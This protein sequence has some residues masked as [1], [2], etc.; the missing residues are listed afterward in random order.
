MTI[1]FNEIPAR[2]ERP[3]EYVEIAALYSALGILPFP[4]RALIVA[5]KLAAAGTAVVGTAYTI[6]RKQDATALFGA[7]SQAET[8]AW[9]YLAANSTVPLDVMAVADAGGSTAATGNFTI[10]AAATANGTPAVSVGGTRYYIGTVAGDTTA[11]S[12]TALAAAINA[13]PQCVVTASAATNVVTLTAKNKGVEGNNI[14]LYVS[15][16]FGDILPAGMAIT[17]TA[18]ATGATNPSIATSLTAIT[19]VWYTDIAMAWTDATNIGLLSA[20]LTRRYSAMTVRD[21]HAYIAIVGTYS[22]TVTAI[23]AMNSRFISPLPAKIFPSVPWAVTASMMGVAADRLTSDPARPLRGIVL[24]NLI[25]TR[26]I[27]RWTETEQELLLENGG[28][29]FI[30]TSTGQMVLTRV[31]TSYL[32]NAAGVADP[33]FHEIQEAKVATR[34]RYDWRTYF[35]LTY[36]SNKLADDK[37]LAAESD[38]SIVTI[39]RIRGSWAARMQV[40]ARAGWVENEVAMA[41]TAVFERNASNRNRVD[42]STPYQR[43]GMM[44]VLAQQLLFQV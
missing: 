37:S 44:N 9:A 3:G 13:D 11:T 20:E 29:T 33:A 32:T 4:A 43:V 31:V 1:S 5:Q 2:L 23:A 30:V 39:G 42:C 17:V 24:P 35:A 18:M 41:R 36:P 34:I 21:A 26:P 10:T 22:Q 8:M 14:D 25:G 7:G 15:P 12:A 19:G 28:S 38:P 16:A 40:W 6:T 27:D